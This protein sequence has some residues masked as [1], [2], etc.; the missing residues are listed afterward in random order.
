M[1]GERRGFFRLPVA[2]EVDAIRGFDAKGRPVGALEARITDIG[3]GGARL[4]VTEGKLSPG[5]RLVMRFVLADE[6]LDLK[7]R[8]AWTDEESEDGSVSAGVAFED[9]DAALRRRILASMN[10][11]RRLHDSQQ[12]ERTARILR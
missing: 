11:H 12:A 9:Q 8:V 7:A 2:V 3:G 10:E 6:T 1:R 5:T 4:Q